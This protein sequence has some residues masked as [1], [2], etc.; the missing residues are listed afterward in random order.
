MTAEE[1]DAAGRWLKKA[2][3]AR[4][5]G[6]ELSHH[7]GYPPGS[8]GPADTGNHRNGTSEKRV[9]TDAGAIAVE[10]PRDRAGTF[11]PQLIP[12]HA[13]RLAAST[14]RCS[15]SDLAGAAQRR[16]RL[17]TPRPALA[18]GAQPVCDSLRRPVSERTGVKCVRD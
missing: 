12:K 18:C 5:L 16:G 14:T 4:M 17:V 8:S 3:M 15:R 1:I 13:R 10:V 9:L 2:L 7:P 6:A 11:E